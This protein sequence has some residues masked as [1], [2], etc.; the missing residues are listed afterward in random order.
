MPFIQP[1]ES[2]LQEAL[3][4]ISPKLGFKRGW[5]Q[6]PKLMSSKHQPLVV[7]GL[8]ELRSRNIVARCP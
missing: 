1:S 8:A 4:A 3:P 2:I 6:G 7:Q 5:L